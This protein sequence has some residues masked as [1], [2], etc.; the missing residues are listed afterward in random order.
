MALFAGC[1]YQILVGEHPLFQPG[2]EHTVSDPSLFLDSYA[3]DPQQLTA[4]LTHLE[5]EACL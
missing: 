4:A 3:I 5:A 2:D 1:N